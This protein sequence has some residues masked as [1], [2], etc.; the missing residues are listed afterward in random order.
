MCVVAG[1]TRGDLSGTRT[2]NTGNYD[3][4][5]RKYDSAGAE[6]STYLFGSDAAD[7]VGF[8]AAVNARGPVVVAGYTAGVLPGQSGPVNGQDAFV[9]WIYEACR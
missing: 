7:N 4:F 3:V 2:T 5:I 9:H 1:I 8:G 6:L